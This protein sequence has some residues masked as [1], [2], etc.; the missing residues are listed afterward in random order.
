VSACMLRGGERGQGSGAG[1]EPLGRR[2][3]TREE[4]GA[5]TA[6]PQETLRFIT[7]DLTEVRSGRHSH[8]TLFV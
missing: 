4:H 3:R 7:I 6:C 1:D 5:P 8:E 2:D